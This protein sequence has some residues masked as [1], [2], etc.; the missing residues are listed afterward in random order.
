MSK[1]KMIYSNFNE[2]TGVSVVK[3]TTPLGEFEGTSKLHD[4]DREISSRYAGCQYAEM[5]AIMNYMKKRI[6]ILKIELNSLEKHNK[7]MLNRKDYNHNS[8][9]MRALRKDIYLLKKSIVSWQERLK[10]LH[11]H[12]LNSMTQREKVINRMMT[13]KGDETDNDRNTN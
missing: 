10:S 5:K 8:M 9:E 2:K 13:K 12:M 7:S 3:I 11:T 1:I 6:Q 4:E